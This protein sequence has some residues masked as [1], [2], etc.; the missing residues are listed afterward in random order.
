MNKREKRVFDE[1]RLRN[2]ERYFEKIVSIPERAE[3]VIDVK[4]KIDAIKR[5]MKY[6]M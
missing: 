4:C 1:V 3:D 6:D 5:E 2:L